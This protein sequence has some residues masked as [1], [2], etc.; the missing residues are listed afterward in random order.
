MKTS[1][2]PDIQKIDDG[3]LEAEPSDTY[4]AVI[5]DSTH[6]VSREPYLWDMVDAVDDPLF[7]ICIHIY[8]NYHDQ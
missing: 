7:K 4:F 5:E 3:Y 8:D 1:D 2:L 6:W